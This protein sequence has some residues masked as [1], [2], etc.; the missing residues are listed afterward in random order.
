MDFPEPEKC[1]LMK[2][3]YIVAQPFNHTYLA[4]TFLNDA[5]SFINDNADNPFFF[6][7]PLAHPHVSLFASPQFA[8]K[9]RRGEL[10]ELIFYKIV[11]S[12]SQ[13]LDLYC[14]L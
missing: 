11:K 5:V 7:Y 13:K 3:D 9:S 14:N 10:A 1:I 2:E 12:L 6:Y 8:G 4:Q